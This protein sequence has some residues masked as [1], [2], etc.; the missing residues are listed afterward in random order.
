MVRDV[1][2]IRID[3]AR[4]ELRKVAGAGTPIL[5]LHE[6]LGSL[7]LWDTFP[8]RLAAATGHPVIVW[9]RQGFGRSDPLPE[10]PGT[11]FLERAADQT[12]ALMHALGID[13]AHLYGHSDGTAIALL[14]AA[15]AP[16]RVKSLVLEAPHVTVEPGALQAI[17]RMRER[18]DTGDLRER[19][20]RHHD[21]PDAVFWNWAWIWLNPHF[22]DWSIEG[23]LQAVRAPT[24]L[25][26]G[27]DD[28]YFSIDQ[29]RRIEA[30][31]S[32]AKAIIIADCGHSPFRERPDLVVPA[33]TQH[34][35]ATDAE[36][37]PSL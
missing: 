10:P 9:S 4:I 1:K 2:F 17:E 14:V 13:E 34:V 16:E 3:G 23:S 28:T 7:S 19:L 37:S 30:L 24:L 29:M 22:R 12:L 36:S 21:N 15:S 33:V 35:L 31:V 20:A 26:H 32:S 25:F 11:D 27:Q 6:A 18:F 8:E 5:L